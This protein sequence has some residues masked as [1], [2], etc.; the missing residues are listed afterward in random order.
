MIDLKKAVILFLMFGALANALKSQD[1]FEAAEQGDVERI[2]IL[3]AANPELVNAVDPWKRPPLLLAARGVHFEAIKLLVDKGADVNADAGGSGTTALHSAAYRGH[4]QAAAYLLEKGADINAV[5]NTGNTPLSYAITAGHKETAA[6]LESRGGG[7]PLKG[8]SAKR[9]LHGAASRGH[10]ALVDYMMTKKVSLDSENGNG[11]TLL[12]SVCSGGIADLAGKLVSLGFDADKKDRYGL[13]P[14]HYA[15]ENGHRAAAESLLE[16]GA[17]IEAEALDGRRPIHLARAADKQEVIDM[18]ISREAEIGPPSF[19]VLKGR[20]LGQKTPGLKPEMFAPGII[21]GPDWEHASP[22]FSPD[23]SEVHWA[24]ISD[25]MRL[26]HMRFEG[27]KW[28]PP[29]ISSFAAGESAC[30]PAFSHDGLRLFYVSYRPLVES[31]PNPGYGISLWFVEKTDAGWSEP[32]PV[33]QPVNT[34]NIFG[35]SMTRDGTL[36]Y[37]DGSG[38]T[39]DIYRT[40]WVDGGYADPEKLSDAVNT[41]A[42][43][44]EPFIAPDESYLIF[45]SMRD[46]GFGGAD[47]YI[48]FRKEDGSWSKAR[49]LGN[50]INTEHAERFPY[51]TRDGKY[52]FFGSDRNGNRGDIFWVYA[53]IVEKFR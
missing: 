4:R 42:D 31:E 6:L 45:K 20:Y 12:H 7:V 1:I 37:A 24:A 17:D 5:D 16:A 32:K 10:K 50:R 39:F 49:N 26:M 40:E 46:G 47:L 9:L 52:F 3:L 14:L 19:P 33:G 8:E 43:E 34:G 22:R 27:G 11:G 25:Q 21:S 35:F 53:V 29:K 36:Y 15:A 44:D 38:G 51:V 30:Y 48:C 13:S 28:S 41:E 23:G 2:R 18:L